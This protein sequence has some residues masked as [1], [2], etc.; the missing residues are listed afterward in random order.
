[1]ASKAVWRSTPSISNRILPGRMVAT[2]CSGAPLPLPIR[3]SA[4]FLVMGLS[5]KSRI[6]TLPPR[7]M[8]RVMATRAASIC[9]SVI[10]AHSIAFRPYS[11][12]EIS[13]P[14]HALPAMRP[15]CCFRYF[16]FFGIIMAVSPQSLL[17]LAAFR[18]LGRL[19]GRLLRR[20]VLGL[21]GRSLVA[22]LL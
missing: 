11:P 12:Y 21:G 15:R 17:V 14:R 6:Q 10:H 5:G 1:M 22:R 7:L 4:G 19:F 13:E 8:E 20:L 18:L 16:T 2:H 3:V 9:R